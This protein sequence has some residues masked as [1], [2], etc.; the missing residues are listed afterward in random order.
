MSYK[1][2]DLN[3]SRILK[4][5]YLTGFKVFTITTNKKLT[6][7]RLKIRLVII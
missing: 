7:K 2:K 3:N 1:E 5:Y 4:T 6:K